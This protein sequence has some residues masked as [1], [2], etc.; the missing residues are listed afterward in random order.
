MSFVLTVY[1]RA[2]ASDLAARAAIPQ[3]HHYLAQL[4]RRRITAGL[5]LRDRIDAVRG[6]LISVPMNT[7]L[8]GNPVQQEGAP[9]ER[10][11]ALQILGLDADATYRQIESA[12][13]LMVKVWHPDR[14][15]SDPKLKETAEE[16]LKSINSAHAYLASQPETRSRR[17]PDKK[18]APQGTAINPVRQPD[19][20]AFLAPPPVSGIFLRGLIL[21]AALAVPIVLLI[22]LDSWL[23]TNP[24]SSAFYM[25]R[26]SQVLLAL[27]ANVNTAKQNLAQSLHRILPA[28]AASGAPP[29]GEPSTT[30]ATDINAANGVPVPRVPMPYVTVGLTPAEVASVMGPPIS[31]ATNAL[32]YRN[33]VFYLHNG[34]V[35]GWKVDPSLI[36]LRVKLWPAP[37]TDPHVVNFTIGTTK[38]NVIAVQGTPT[39]LTENKLGYGASAVFLENGR[40]IG[41]NDSHSSQR[42]HV[43]AR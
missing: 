9:C 29:Q 10:C 34:V 26:R 43:A 33:A 1:A 15:Q 27:R 21:I 18:P 7:C 39:L 11:S 6:H 4:L 35:A 13:R 19:R 22:G 14:F 20:N 32:R 16:K 24:A 36:P 2:N 25:P 3:S 42:L 30:A 38:D 40:V 41:W 37:G 31:A 28:R 17:Q 8:C 5:R 12:Y 23:S